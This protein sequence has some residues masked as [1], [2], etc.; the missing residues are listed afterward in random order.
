M[1]R[2]DRAA[3]RVEPVFV[4]VMG[5]AAAVTILLVT[6]PHGPALSP[7]SAAYVSAAEH[8]ADGEGLTAYG[9]ERFVSW[10]PGFPL[11]LAALSALFEVSAITAGRVANAILLGS[12]IGAAWLV[13]RRVVTSATTRVVGVSLVAAATCLHLVTSYVWSEPLFVLMTLL[14]L[15]ALHEAIRRPDSGGWLLAAALLAASCFFIRYVGAVVI[16]TASVAMFVAGWRQLSARRRLMRAAVFAVIASAGPVAWVVRNLAVA[17]TLTGDVG[18]P[19]QSFT[20]NAHDA[21]R[22]LALLVVPSAVPA[23]GVVLLLLCVVAVA[24]VVQVRSTGLG[25][26][27]RFAWLLAVFVALYLVVLVVMASRG[28]LELGDRLL[29]PIFVPL[30]ALAA[31]VLD[32]A[33]VRWRERR[34]PYSGLVAP[35]ALALCAAGLVWG[36][37]EAGRD[38]T[39]GVDYAG[40]RWTDSDLMATVERT[41]LPNTVYSN[42]PGGLFLQTSIDA[43]C[44]PEELVQGAFCNGFTTKSADLAEQIGTEPAALVF[45]SPDYYGERRTAE[46]PAW[47]RVARTTNATDGTMYL[48]QAAN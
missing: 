29:S 33:A 3:A 8:L 45:F 28:H 44:W 34:G 48:L 24:A 21:V 27:W 1:E 12:I 36:S 5:I 16:V 14:A 15:L 2:L 41:E 17:D 23:R 32:R 31:A 40:R 47:L 38:T 25:G 20:E 30:V 26:D 39:D 46:I 35:G 22:G 13:L 42:V 9:G 19:G 43:R 6:G 10:P 18:G 4:V 37:A 11:L 7:D